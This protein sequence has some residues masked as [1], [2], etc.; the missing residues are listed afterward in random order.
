[1]RRIPRDV[2]YGVPE[3]ATSVL[4][5][6]E[7]A[8]F[9]AWV[10][11]GWVRD[12]LLGAPCHDVDVTTSAHWRDVERVLSSHGIEVHETGVAHGTV[13]A[14][15]GG[16]PI[17]ITTYRVESSYTDRRHPD[18]VVFVKDVR[19]DLAR[20]DFTIN[21]MAY[22]PD[23]GLLDPFDGRGDLCRGLIRAVGEP[24]LRFSEDALRVLRAVRFACRLGF[25]V[26]SE[27]Q[28]ALV[29]CA[30]GLDDI[31]S[32][33][34]GQELDGIVCTGRMGWALMNSFEAL[35]VAVPELAPMRGFDQRSPYHAYDVL[36][37]TSRV[38]RAVEEFTGGGAS[39]ELR[40]A[41]F[42]HDIA[43]PA[44]FTQ[45]ETGRG[46]F[47]G[48][49][50]VGARMCEMIM[51]RLAIPHDVTVSVRTL[52]RLHDHVVKPTP[53]SM[54]RT[55][56]KFETACPGRAAQLS[57]ALLD[58]KRA[59]AVA[60]VPVCASYAIELDEVERVLRQELSRNAVF[61]LRDLAVN[62]SDVISATGI[63]PGP[64]VGLILKGL[65]SAVV[66]GELPNDRK[67][68]IESMRIQ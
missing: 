28:D 61:R 62:G 33:R 42:L 39:R 60:K 11:G 2:A 54:R 3:Y 55:L 9:E 34:I 13:T 27:T 63:K 26:E 19:Q 45:D 31:A 8:G 21:S 4:R 56:L 16:K 17:E 14:M 30:E 52:V 22:H 57:F 29:R 15:V 6:L 65:L 51:R 35:A 66:N 5:V 32:E 50:K 46:H 48:H 10:V 41:A 67:A 43:K 38:C 20:R 49:P 1:M 12:A 25:T 53:R 18:R 23:R 59:D 36:E 7:E 47:F 44:T 68:L 37:H 40:W 24:E 58:L 64:G